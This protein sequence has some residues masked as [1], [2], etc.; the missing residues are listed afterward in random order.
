MNEIVFLVAKDNSAYVDWQ[1]N[2]LY[3]SFL[4]VYK[5]EKRIKF[6]AAVMNEKNF[7]RPRYPFFLCSKKI[8]KIL[9]EGDYYSPFNRIT[10]IWDFL[11]NSQN[12]NRKI[13]ILDQDFLLINKFLI[14][15]PVAGQNYGYLDINLDHTAKKTFYFYKKYINEN[16]IE[17]YLRPIGSPIF[18]DEN[19]LR[20]IIDRWFQLT[21]FFRYHKHKDNPLYKEW[22]CEMYGL[23]YALGELGIKSELFDATSFVIFGSKNPSFYHFCYG[24]YDE[25]NNIIF[26]KK[27]YTPWDEISPKEK[28]SDLNILKFINYFNELSSNIKSEINTNE[29][30]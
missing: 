6:I 17:N 28:P 2:I 30:K 15:S 16:I 23:V 5:N 24:L 9:V 29:Q 4:N 11:K 22:I 26:D 12:K 25:L 13:I 14:N 18:L 3:E 21:Y 27:K 7:K 1:T 20:N 10:L 8:K 19:I